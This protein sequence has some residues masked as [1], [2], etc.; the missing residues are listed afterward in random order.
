MNF[1]IRFTPRWVIGIGI[2]TVALVAALFMTGAAQTL[3]ERAD[4]GPLSAASAPSTGVGAAVRSSVGTESKSFVGLGLI[5]AYVIGLAVLITAWAM[6]RRS[7]RRLV[8]QAV[9]PV[10]G[11]GQGG[12]KPLPIQRY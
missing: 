7:R 4:K 3:I 12:A 2:V 9:T 6:A 10:P 11:R 5:A 8:G 1:S